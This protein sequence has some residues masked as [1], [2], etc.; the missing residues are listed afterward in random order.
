MDGNQVVDLLKPGRNNNT[1]FVTINAPGYDPVETEL[2]Y[3]R[4][5]ATD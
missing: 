2:N 3:D 5:P 4:P 1:Y